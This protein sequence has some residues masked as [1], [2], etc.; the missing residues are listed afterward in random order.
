MDSRLASAEAARPLAIGI[1]I[2]LFAILAASATYFLRPELSVVSRPSPAPN[3]SLSPP[4]PPLPVVEP[5]IVRELKPEQARAINA[6]IPFVRAPNPP[7]RPFVFPA[8]P[9]ERERAL[10]CLAT[11]A[12]YEAGD[13]RSGQQAVV[14]VVLNRLRHPAYPKSVCGVVFQGSERKTGCQFTFTCDGALART[15]PVAAWQRARAV[16]D[17]A[18]SGF[19]FKQVGTATSYHTDWVVPYWSASLDKITQLK[20][21]IFFRWRGWWGM[22]GAFLRGYTGPESLDPRIAYLADAANLPAPAPAPALASA[23]QIDGVAPAPPRPALTITGVGK[24][25][26]KGSVVRLASTDG[27]EF[28]LELDPSAYPGSYAIVALSICRDRPACTVMGWTKPERIPRA[29]PVPL[30]IL[31]SVSFLYR[32]NTRNGREDVYWNCGQ[33]PRENLAQCMPGT[34]PE[35]ALKTD[36]VALAK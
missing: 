3:V 27:A 6:A 16:A 9:A 13:D 25:D 18:L 26:L 5:L 2:A 30:P 14:Q 28:A 8:P 15:P 34:E 7:A 20:T 33:F 21:H 29:L 23:M 12:L 10:T 22:P 32:R 35:T 36:A 17:A 4:A 11:A 19:V 24:A 1:G 31:R